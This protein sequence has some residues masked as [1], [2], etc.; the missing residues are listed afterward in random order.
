[1]MRKSTA[2][3]LLATLATA[4]CHGANAEGSGRTVSR[5][6]QV[7]NFQQIEVAGS[8]DVEV[9]TGAN[10][11]VSARGG[12]NLLDHT[13]VEVSGGKL[14]IH[15]E[16]T[17]GFINFGHHGH[18][19]FTVTVPQLTGANIAGSGDMT[20]DHVQ[21][22]GFEGQIAGSGSL[23]LASLDVQQLKLSIA[24]SGDVKGGSGKAKSAEYQIAGSGDIDAGSVQAQDA[25]M[26]I[27][28]SGGIK[29]HAVG[30][31]DISIMG[32]G[33][34]DVSGGAKCQISKA[35]SGT[36]RCS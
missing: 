14:L 1:M 26:S 33:D 32:S 4:G 24:G 8:Y 9:K 34:V 15:P 27:A 20:I 31:A 28:G 2:A 6:Y 19:T 25:K 13:V 30:T 22:E 16:K 23:K 35:G 7:G 29:A 21:G 3:A 36:A 11:S 5:N 17:R 10:V 18:A 12:Q